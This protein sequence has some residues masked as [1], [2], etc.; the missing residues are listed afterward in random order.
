MDELENLGCKQVTGDEAFFTK[1]SQDNKLECL[2]VDDFNCSGNEK[3]H[4]EVTEKIQ[5][6]F[7]FGK[8]EKRAF[9]FT[10]LDFQDEDNK[11][12]INQN[13]YCESLE[14]KPSFLFCQNAHY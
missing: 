4:E 1:H 5:K 12:V 8:V 6:K 14:A 13:A 9:R 7:T 10:G 3:F 11:I 2:H